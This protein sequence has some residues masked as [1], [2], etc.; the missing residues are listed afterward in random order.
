MSIWKIMNLAAWGFFIL[1][2]VLMAMDF[3]KVE[4]ERKAVV[5]LEPQPSSEREAL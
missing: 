1:I 3:V 5:K 4:K 2:L